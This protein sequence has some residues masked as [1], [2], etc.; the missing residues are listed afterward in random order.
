VT[1]DKVARKH[2]WYLVGL[3]ASDGCLSSDGRHLDITAKEREF[4]DTG[5]DTLGLSNRIGVKSRGKINQTYRIQFGSV[6]F[7]DFLLSLGLVPSKSL[8]L[9]SL[10]VPDEYFPD[11]LRGQ[12]DGDGNIRRWLHPTNG[13]EQWV[14]RIYS[15]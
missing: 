14:L 8:R 3:I 15:A 2:L 1:W 11:F 13:R 6:V 5:R 12:I 4:L 9:G 10:D 7:Y